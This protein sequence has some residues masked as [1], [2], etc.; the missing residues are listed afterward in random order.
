MHIY[1][2]KIY[3][4]DTDQAGV[5]HHSNYLKYFEAGRIEH[6][7]NLGIL[8]S[9]LQ[10]SSIGFVPVDIQI[11]YKAPLRLDDR[12]RVETSLTTLKKATI[13]FKQEVFKNKTCCCTAMVK[14]ACL[15]ESDYKVIP[16]PKELYETLKT[17][18]VKS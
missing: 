3:F 9:E 11:Q 6:L 10:Q 18:L 14:L 8:Y 16:M 17:A 1:E 13:I 15:N 2:H 5:V 12:Y 7:K 4:H